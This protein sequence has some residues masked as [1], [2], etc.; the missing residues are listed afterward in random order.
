LLIKKGRKKGRK[1]ERKKGR[2]EERHLRKYR[3]DMVTIT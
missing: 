3:I 1:R 2:K